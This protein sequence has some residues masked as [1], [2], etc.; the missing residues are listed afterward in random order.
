MSGYQTSLAPHASVLLSVKPQG[1]AHFQAEVGAWAGSAGFGNT[2][3]GHEG[4]GYVTG[5]TTEGSSG[6]VAISVPKA[7]NRRLVFRAANATGSLSTLTVRALDPKTGHVHG[8]ATLHVPN[9]AAWTSWSDV[10]VTLAMAAGT[11]LVVCSVES[12][13]QGGVNLDYVALA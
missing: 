11:N 3:G 5:L 10:S 1:P 9:A 12:A 4:M 7:G 13:A 8:T 2:F 6:A